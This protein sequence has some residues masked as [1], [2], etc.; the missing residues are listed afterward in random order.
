MSDTDTKRIDA[1]LNRGVISDIL[2]DKEQF[3]DRLLSGEKLKF[4]IG[5]DPTSRSLHL[6]HAENLMLL[7]DFRRLGH[8]VIVL[9][10]DFTAQ[11]GD[12]T[13]R[14]AV[15]TQ[16]S[17]EEVK[18]NAKYW[19][20]QIQPLLG[21]DDNYNPPKILFNNDWLS[22]LTFADVIDLASNFTVQQMIERDMFQNRLHKNQ[23]IYL[24]EFL[25]PLM[26]GYDSVAMDVD[27]ELCGTDQTFNAMAGRTLSKKLLGKDKFVVV[28]NLLENPKTGELMSKS[29]GTGVML[30]GAVNDIYGAIMAQPD[31][32]I[33]VLL[34]SNTRLPLEE[35][36]EIIK[37][38]PR[39]AKARAALE[40]T[41]IFYGTEASEAAQEAFEKQF[42]QGELP[43]DIP[44]FA[45]SQTEWNVEDILSK[46][47]LVKSKSEARRALE[48]KGVKVNGIPVE[49]SSVTV[50]N[51]DVLQVG[52]RR[53]AR[54][55]LQ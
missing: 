51:G 25:Y 28:T 45:T 42:S 24:H 16:L 10:G 34:I 17:A 13:E 37:Q 53:F 9:F 44:E 48:Q 3:R 15:R 31:E 22:K 33:E 30:D 19:Q 21:F 32:M 55:K 43:E 41:R 38:P 7:E 5:L 50:S 27:V 36:E 46:T 52:K 2:P 8:E 40:I 14:E 49:D 23:P 11:I 12:P 29:K 20:K 47:G 4:Y 35:I 39:Q 54:V 18:D 26:Q 1:I 6:G